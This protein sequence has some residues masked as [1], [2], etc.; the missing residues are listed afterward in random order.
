MC[1]PVDGQG[2]HL[3]PGW[4]GGPPGRP[5]GLPVQGPEE[6]RP[7][8]P[9]SKDQKN[10]DPLVMQGTMPPGAWSRGQGG[11]DPWP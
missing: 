1:P 10:Q 5:P 11:G 7:P 6:P 2:T 8:G 4:T 3:S 9:L